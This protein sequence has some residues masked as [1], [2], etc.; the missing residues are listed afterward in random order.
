MPG[1]CAYARRNSTEDCN[2][3]F[4]GISQGE[5]QPDDLR[6]VSGA[7]IQVPE[8]WNSGAVGTT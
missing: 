1:S 5:K 2:I 6:K 3:Q 8:L 4:H 7:E